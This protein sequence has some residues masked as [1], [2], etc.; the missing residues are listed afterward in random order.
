MIIACYV[1]DEKMAR[2]LHEVLTVARLQF[3]ICASE[4]SF[5][6]AIRRESYDLILVDTGTER[7]AEERFFSW[8]NCRSG[9]STPVIMFSDVYSPSRVARALEA[10]AD[11]F[12]AKPFDPL[13]L[14]ARINAIIRRCKRSYSEKT[15]SLAGFVLDQDRGTLLDCGVPIELTPREFTMAWLLFASPGIYLSR[16]TISMA[17]WG[18]DRDIANR[19]IEQ[20]VYKLRKK[21][22]LSAERGITIRTGYTQGYRL[23]L[24]RE[25]KTHAMENNSA[26]SLP[27]SIADAPSSDGVTTEIVPMPYLL[28]KLTDC[29][30]VANS[31]NEI[32]T[33]QPAVLPDRLHSFG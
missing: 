4:S 26:P 13:E 10:G 18:V 15:I 17:I 24:V 22:Q 30:P 7:E 33:V 20:H 23:E 29:E 8:L 19:T 2:A 25:Q 31:H 3:E 32:F 1:H 16:E 11:D 27:M 14:A 28:P 12:V 9:A 5:L 21:M 6:R